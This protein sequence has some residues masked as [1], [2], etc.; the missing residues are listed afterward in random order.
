[1]KRA[2]GIAGLISATLAMLALSTSL[3]IYFVEFHNLLS[4]RPPLTLSV[5]CDDTVPGGIAILGMG[6]ALAGLI[7]TITS[8]RESRHTHAVTSLA[9]AIGSLLGLLNM[10]YLLSLESG[11][12]RALSHP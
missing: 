5:N 1:M 7:L 2:R 9:L 8:W 4:A 6:F 10:P 12:L 3:G 11:F